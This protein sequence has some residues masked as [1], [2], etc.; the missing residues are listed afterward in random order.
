MSRANN[1]ADTSP[2][3]DVPVKHDRLGSIVVE[4]WRWEK[5]PE[6]WV[7]SQRE[8]RAAERYQLR[9]VSSESDRTSEQDH[10]E[11]DDI[12][13]EQFTV[14]SLSEKATKGQAIHVGARYV[15]SHRVKLLMQ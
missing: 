2:A 15:A 12:D 6:E 14:H 1:Q 7:P 3:I 8:R 13:E 5:D 4:I 9:E 11:T 10:A